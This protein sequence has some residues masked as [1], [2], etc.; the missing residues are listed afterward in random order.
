MAVSLILGILCFDTFSILNN[1]KLQNKQKKTMHF[2]PVEKINS[3][4]DGQTSFIGKEQISV[5]SAKFMYKPQ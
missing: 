1:R 4:N 5:A 3:L 2:F